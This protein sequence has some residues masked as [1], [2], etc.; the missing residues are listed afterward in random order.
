MNLSFPNL[1]IPKAQQADAPSILESNQVDKL[2]L[3]VGVG[4]KRSC[5]ETHIPGFTSAK[6]ISS[7]TVEGGSLRRPYMVYT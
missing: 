6:T 7:T 4:M 3:F 2:G 5:A 1:E